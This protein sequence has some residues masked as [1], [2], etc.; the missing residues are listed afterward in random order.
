MCSLHIS[1]AEGKEVQSRIATL[2]YFS[3]PFPSFFSVHSSHF[4]SRI[5]ATHCKSPF[6]FQNLHLIPSS[7]TEHSCSSPPPSLSFFLKACTPPYLSRK[8]LIFSQGLKSLSHVQ[9][10][11]PSSSLSRNADSLSQGS[12]PFLS[13]SL[14]VKNHS[15]SLSKISLH[16]FSQYCPFAE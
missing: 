15:L 16:S 5:V 6:L 8:A 9:Q 3:Y 10:Q 12:Q 4:L 14:L 11:V 2:H 13:L 7:F 1:V